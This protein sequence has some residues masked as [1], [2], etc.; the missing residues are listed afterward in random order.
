MLSSPS[1]ERALALVLRVQATILA[2]ALGAVV[3]P[4]AWMAEAHRAVGLG[5]MPASPLVEYLTRSVSL[6]YGTWGALLLFYLA[7]DVRRYAPV[8]RFLGAVSA[9]MA[10]VFVVLDFWVGM[11]LPWAL[12][13]GPMIL[14]F[15]L[16]M[17]VLAGRVERGAATAAA[18]AAPSVSPT[19][20]PGAATPG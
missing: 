1:P 15:A 16:L 11:P 10:V 14:A 8:I 7:T 13:E 3:M 20:R 6:I 9:G 18:A 12:V 2:L 5:E 17:V 19:D 4:T